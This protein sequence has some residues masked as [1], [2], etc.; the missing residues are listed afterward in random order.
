MISSFNQDSWYYNYFQGYFVYMQK[1]FTQSLSQRSNYLFQLENDKNKGIF[2]DA[3]QILLK[4][5]FS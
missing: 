4:Q 5:G 3:P 2:R 1:L